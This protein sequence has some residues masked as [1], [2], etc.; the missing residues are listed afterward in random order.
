MEQTCKW[1]H[2]INV[3]SSIERV[4]V[5]TNNVLY[6]DYVVLDTFWAYA[7]P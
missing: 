4:Y 7:H 2:C 6:D 1:F 3:V 5:I